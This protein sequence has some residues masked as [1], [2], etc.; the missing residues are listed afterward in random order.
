MRVTIDN[1]QVEYLISLYMYY[2]LEEYGDGILFL[3]D[4]IDNY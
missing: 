2:M 3:I 4:M 1:D